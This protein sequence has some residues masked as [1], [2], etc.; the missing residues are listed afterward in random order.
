MTTSAINLHLQRQAR[1]T[2]LDALQARLGLISDADDLADILVEFATLQQTQ[3]VVHLMERACDYTHSAGVAPE[4]QPEGVDDKA[5][6][7][8]Q[9]LEEWGIPIPFY[10]YNWAQRL[11]VGDEVAIV[12]GVHS[13]HTT[14]VGRV[15]HITTSS[16]HVAWTM[17]GVATET[18]FK[19]YGGSNRTHTLY[20]LTPI[21]RAAATLTM[22]ST[23]NEKQ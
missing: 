11:K 22:A 14:Y 17:E 21:L 15:A 1:Q 3:M 20:P 19:R 4:Y 18:K 16:I 7:I 12:S 10:R 23:T 5:A 6:G 9:V 2:A 8:A 13:F